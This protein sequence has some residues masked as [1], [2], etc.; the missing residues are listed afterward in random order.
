MA[1]SLDP[2]RLDAAFELVRRRVREGDIPGAVLAIAN[3]A[4]DLRS[5]AFSPPAGPSLTIESRFLIASITKPIVAT[6]VMQLV[7][8]GELVLEAPVQRYLPEFAPPPAGERIPGGGGITTWHLLTHTSGLDDY[9]SDVAEGR[10]TTTADQLYRLAC[11]RPL[12]FAPGAE[13]R[14]CSD[15]FF[16]LGELIR[17]ISGLPYPD[18]L[19]TRIFEPLG[20]TA[21][22][23]DPGAADDLLRTPAFRVGLPGQVPEEAL[24]G[25][26]ALAHP[27]GGLWSTA[28]DLLRFGRACLND[29]KLD[30]TQLL[31]PAFVELMTREHTAGILE[32]GTP[33][34]AP[35]YG[36]GWG[37]SGLSGTRLGSAR[38]F[39]HG[40]ATGTRLWVDPEEDLVVVFLMNQ[41]GADDSYSLAAIQAVYAAF[42]APD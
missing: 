29:G 9:L 16:V 40:G 1:R 5:D 23:F 13:Y 26:A 28:P 4:G 12:R 10:M 7:E 38:Q 3:R 22:S 32:A 30:A 14:Y 37:K 2:A 21:T 35:R 27:G 19:R 15:S 6:A 33:P 11:T 31:A 24:A 42:D 36:L 39:D 18:Y 20:M 34:R 17:T 41:W 25:L 8:A